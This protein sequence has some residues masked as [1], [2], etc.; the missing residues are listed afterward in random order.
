MSKISKTVNKRL[1]WGKQG[2]PL[3]T[4][5]LLEVQKESY[6]SFL[7]ENISRHLEEIS[8]I[9]DFTGKNW[10]LSFLKHQ[11]GKS[12]TTPLQAVYKGITY[13]T[14]LRFITK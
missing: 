12:Q 5:S 3:P 4:L 9:E 11:F 2:I 7:L 8:P 13:D 6:D 10:S 1:F 14:T